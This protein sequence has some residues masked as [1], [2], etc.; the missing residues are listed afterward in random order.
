MLTDFFLFR[1]RVHAK[2]ICFSKEALLSVNFLV[3][4]RILRKQKDAT[5]SMVD[6]A[7]IGAVQKKLTAV[8]CVT[9]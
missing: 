6:P 5:C 3:G 9:M 8:F 1:H 7:D 4:F 2:L